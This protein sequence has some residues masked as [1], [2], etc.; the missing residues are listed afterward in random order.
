ATDWIKSIPMDLECYVKE[1]YTQITIKPLYDEKRSN[2]LSLIN[3]TKNVQ[4]IEEKNHTQNLI[5]T[6]EFHQKGASIIQEIGY[7]LALLSDILHA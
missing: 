6:K 1:L 2:I 7:T 4:L 3:G 5:S